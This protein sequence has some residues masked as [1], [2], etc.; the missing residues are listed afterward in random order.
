M[1]RD[2]GL[3][4]LLLVDVEQCLHPHTDRWRTSEH[5]A[6][7]TRLEAILGKLIG[8]ERQPASAAVVQDVL[9]T[10]PVGF[11]G[12]WSRAGLMEAV[13]ATDHGFRQWRSC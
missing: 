1:A 5:R 11:R 2:A 12:P 3:A 8:V 7:A 10:A 9:V 6:G 13:P 4:A